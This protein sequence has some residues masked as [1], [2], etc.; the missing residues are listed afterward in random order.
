[1]VEEIYAMVLEKTAEVARE[2]GL[3]MVL[4]RSE[5][6]LPAVSGSDL[7]MAISTHK[8][9]FCEGCVDITEEVME[10]VN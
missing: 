3:E 5:P 1:M 10:R 7:S 6:K 9:L 4:E 2:K 8:V